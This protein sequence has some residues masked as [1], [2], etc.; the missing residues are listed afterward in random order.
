MKFIKNP[1]LIRRF[2]GLLLTLC[3]VFPAWGLALSAEA[4]FVITRQYGW[5]QNGSSH[6]FVLLK[7]E[8]NH[9]ARLEAF[10]TYTF[11]NGEVELVRAPHFI[12]NPDAQVAYGL[13]YKAPYEKVE[14]LF[15]T[16]DL[17]QGRGDASHYLTAQGLKEHQSL[18]VTLANSA[19]DSISPLWITALF[20]QGNLPVHWVTQPFSSLEPGKKATVVLSSP[21][22]FD[23][24]LL[25]AQ[26]EFSFNDLLPGQ[27]EGEGIILAPAP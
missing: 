16:M 12:L 13:T 10:H 14:T 11:S 27:L 24:F 15:C 9:P 17:P 22:A 8:G 18:E 7:N 4:P 25:F 3:L 1:F 21:E 2:F 20:L 19:D 5:V 26:G 6:I 23:D